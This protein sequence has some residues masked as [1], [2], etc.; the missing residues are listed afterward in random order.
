MKD[1]PSRPTR[2]GKPERRTKPHPATPALRKDLDR[3]DRELVELMVRRGMCVTEFAESLRGVEHRVADLMSAV[4]FQAA[5]VEDIPTALRPTVT[6][7]MQEVANGCRELAQRLRVGYLG[8]AFSFSH[9]AL[10][11]F[12]GRTVTSV[13]LP[14]VAAIFEETACGNLDFALVPLENST[15][16]R[17]IDTLTMFGQ[18]PLR[19]LAE[20]PLR[21]RHCLLGMGEMADI[22]TVV[23]KPQASSQCRGWLAK[24]LPDVPLEEAPSTAAAAERA[25][26]EPHVAAIASRQAGLA[27]GL[28]VLA[29]NIEDNRQ[30]ITRFAVIGTQS[31]RRT[32]RD[33]TALLFQL[34]H[35]PG[36]LA[37]AMQIFKRY[38]L[39]LTWIES[40]PAGTDA[41]RKTYLFFV[42]FEGHAEELRPRKALQALARKTTRLEIL[43][44]YAR[45][46][47]RES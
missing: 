19:I 14:T 26:N 9:L 36:A 31:A 40:F 33:K 25:R 38:R 45:V 43:G 22:R 5:L 10:G 3:I 44:S 17:V 7:A 11:Q 37:D 41:L 24:N 46:D 23:S 39:N 47:P 6:I 2:G 13:P 20:V 27:Y 8:P 29:R 15:D 18:Q 12:F 21:I 32:G 1:K 34:P 42:E 28:N 16:G 4:A 30:N 35:Q